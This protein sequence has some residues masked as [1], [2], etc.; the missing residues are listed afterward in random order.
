MNA[1]TRQ[2]SGQG[3]GA[4]AQAWPPLLSSQSPISRIHCW[5]QSYQIKAWCYMKHKHDGLTAALLKVRG[6]VCSQQC[7]CI[8]DWGLLL[9]T[10]F[11]EKLLFYSYLVQWLQGK[12]TEISIWRQ[13]ASPSCGQSTKSRILA[14]ALNYRLNRI[15]VKLL[16]HPTQDLYCLWGHCWFLCDPPNC[17][18]VNQLL[19]H[20]L[21][22]PDFRAS[23]GNL[24]KSSCNFSFMTR[25]MYVCV[26]WSYP[27]FL[28]NIDK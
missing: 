15:L 27:S 13:L 26:W 11:A 3:W 10:R 5:S 7:M 4:S 9:S 20:S 1:C 17:L 28:L 18:V 16:P 21:W 23:P 25:S 19:S 8:S 24:I 22:L 14:C 2:G 12:S 6:N